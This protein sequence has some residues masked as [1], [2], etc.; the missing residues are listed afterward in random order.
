MIPVPPTVPP[1]VPVGGTIFLKPR[2]SNPRLEPGEMACSGMPCPKTCLKTHIFRVR[3]P[4]R[5]AMRVGVV[6]SSRPR[7]ASPAAPL[8]AALLFASRRRGAATLGAFV[9]SGPK[10]LANGLGSRRLRRRHAAR[11]ARIAARPISR[12]LWPVPLCHA[13][14]VAFGEYFSANI[15]GEYQGE[16]SFDEYFYYDLSRLPAFSLYQPPSRVKGFQSRFARL[17][18]LALDPPRYLAGY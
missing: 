9:P 15:S 12:P 1:T 7:L 4:T 8:A 11:Y 6:S 2:A 18:A 13:I 17:A 10:P 14:G 16:Y 3:H 5:Q